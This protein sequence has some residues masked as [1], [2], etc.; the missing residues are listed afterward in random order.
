MGRNN[1]EGSHIPSICKEMCHIY[2]VASTKGAEMV[3]VIKY[4]ILWGV[5]I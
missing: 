1:I 3:R 5:I 2:T 4:F